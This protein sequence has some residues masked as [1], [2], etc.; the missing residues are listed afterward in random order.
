MKALRLA[1]KRKAY[2]RGNRG[3]TERTED[4][5][6]EVTCARRWEISS[7]DDEERRN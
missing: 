3:A 5:G 4:L 7:I 1:Q 6:E 2:H